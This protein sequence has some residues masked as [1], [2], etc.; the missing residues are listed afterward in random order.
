MVLPKNFES[1]LPLT[2]KTLTT[3]GPWTCMNKKWSGKLDGPQDG[4]TLQYSGV[5]QITLGWPGTRTNPGQGLWLPPDKDVLSRDRHQES[6]PTKESFWIRNNTWFMPSRVELA[7]NLELLSLPFPSF[8]VGHFIVI[9]LFLL[10]HGVLRA[11]L[12]LNIQVA[13]L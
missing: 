8:G 10:Y 7:M 13:T 3:L 12:S 9:A 4:H 11:N 1:G 2:G 5:L 6:S